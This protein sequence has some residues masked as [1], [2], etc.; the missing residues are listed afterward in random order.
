MTI[1]SSKPRTARLLAAALALALFT[2]PIIAQEK[3][4]PPDPLATNPDKLPAFPGAEGFGA[5]ATGGR[6]GEVVHVT[7]LN[8]DGPGS[9]REAVSRPGRIVV[10]DVGGV[11]EIQS[12]LSVQSNLTLAGQSAPAPGITIYGDAVSFSHQ[13]NVIVRHIRI[14]QGIDSGRGKKALNVSE[15]HNMIFDHVSAAW[16]RWDTMGITS[17]STNITMQDCIFAEAIDPQRFGGLVDS[18]HG[19]TL[20][21]NLW[22]N[23]QNR[24][25]KIKAH[26]QYFN[27]VVYNWGSGA[28]PGGHSGANWYQDLVNNVFIAGPSSDPDK[29]VFFFASTDNVF[30]R[31]NVADVDKDGRLNARVLVESDY[32]GKTP[33]T[34]HAEPHNHPTIPTRVLEVDDALDHVLKHA[35]ASLWRD[36]MDKRLIDQV[37][38]LGREG[39][40]INTEAEVGGQPAIKP[41]RHPEGY[42]TDRD[43][44]PDAWESSQGLDP[45]DPKDAMEGDGYANIERYLN[46]IADGEVS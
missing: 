23:N 18:S 4:A 36:A 7:N 20:A 26:M 27:N 37:R 41:T 12:P 43:G 5:L 39:K 30:Q 1:P 44:M 3:P 45:R 2:M 35:G 24:N 34:F 31:G 25:P 42:D 32:Q 16:G 29:V 33:P 22:I 17:N 14:R 10:F 8:N 46:A 40:V 6:G 19:V 15:G 21:R 13:Q 9:L 38:S 28:L 11:I